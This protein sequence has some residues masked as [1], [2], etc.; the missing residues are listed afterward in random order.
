MPKLMA[1]DVDG[2]ILFDQQ[3][4][5]ETQQALQRWHEAGHLTICN[6]GRSMEAT[7][8]GLGK[9]DLPFDYYVLYTGAV[10]TNKDLEFLETATVPQDVAR[11][12]IRHF[13]EIPGIAVYA[14][15]L[16]QDYN[17]TPGEFEADIVNHFIPATLE[18]LEQEEFVVIPLLI[19]D[20]T[21][22]EQAYEWITRHYGDVIDCQRNTYI[23]DVVPKG[24]TKASGLRRLIQ[25]H[26]DTPEAEWEIYTIGDSWNDIPM[27]EYAQVS[28]C[29]DYSPPEVQAAATKVVSTAQEFVDWVLAGQPD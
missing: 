17:L 5:P 25:N 4:A 19:P 9:Y 29:F 7:R 28:A 16:E 23:I 1:F 11:E 10:L 27:H 3:I 26:V 8:V 2:T 20:A 24:A 15:T 13:Q 6:T 18:K 12:I 14:T 22:R 21:Q